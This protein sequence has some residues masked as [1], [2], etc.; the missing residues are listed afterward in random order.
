MAYVP[1]VAPA[2]KNVSAKNDTIQKNEYSLERDMMEL[3][4]SFFNP[5][6][7]KCELILP[8]FEEKKT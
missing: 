8:V 4:C 7:T 2:Y 6:N 5:K 3:S 1:N